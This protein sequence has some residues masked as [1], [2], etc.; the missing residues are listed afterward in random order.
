VT[1]RAGGFYQQQEGISITVHSDFDD[2]LDV[3][4][5]RALV[6]ESLPAARPEV[7]LAGFQGALQ[8]FGIHV[9]YHEYLE[10]VDILHH[11]RDQAAFV[12]F[13]GRETFS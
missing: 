9:G 7:C 10:G 1:G 5:G 2:F 4:R 6:P 8:G 13:E 11:G 3:A 12:E